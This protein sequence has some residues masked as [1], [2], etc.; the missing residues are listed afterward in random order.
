MSEE[1]DEKIALECANGDPR[2]AAFQ[3]ELCEIADENPS[4]SFRL[5]CAIDTAARRAFCDRRSPPAPAIDHYARLAAIINDD[6]SLSTHE[7]IEDIARDA[8]HAYETQNAL[9]EENMRLRK[10]APAIDVEGVARSIDAAVT[11]YLISLSEDDGD[12]RSR[13]EVIEDTLRAA[14]GGK[15]Q[16]K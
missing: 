13:R 11:D 5:Y 12:P 16:P 15:E 10:A 9:I 4:L 1:W 2:L 6:G 14:L 8:M 3:K 7:D